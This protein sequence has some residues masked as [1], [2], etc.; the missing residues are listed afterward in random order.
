MDNLSSPP[1]YG[2]HYSEIEQRTI[3]CQHVCVRDLRGYN[4]VMDTTALHQL[5]NDEKLRIIFEL[6]DELAASNAPIHLPAEVVA[7]AHP[8][9]NEL[10][11]NPEIAIDDDELWRR[12]D[13]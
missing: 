12:V 11:A 8:R 3:A 10:I 9:R 4:R 13:G 2:R 7:E 6:W 5:P 1:D